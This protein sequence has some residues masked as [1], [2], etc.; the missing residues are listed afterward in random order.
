[1][2]GAIAGD[3]VGS[4]YEF[5][6]ITN[7]DF[8]PLFAEKCIYTDDTVLTVATADVI[9]DDDTTYSEQ[10]LDYAKAYPNRGYGGTFG[11]MIKLGKLIP[12]NSYG[13]GSAMRVS[14]VGWIHDTLEDT[15]AEAKKSA[16]CT[17]N[18]LEGVKG[19][20]A[21]AGVIFMARTGQ[22]KED[23]K[24]MVEWLGY[25]LS[26]KSYDFRQG[27]FDVT[28]QG[29]IPRCMAVI[30][31]T[32]DF[33]SAQRKTV[34]MGGDVD[35][36]CCIVGAIT[37]AMYG[38]PEGLTEAVYERLPNQMAEVVTA[39]TKKYIN[40]DFVEPENV[41]TMTATLEEQ[42]TSL[43]FGGDNEDSDT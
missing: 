31:E 17:H 10:Y 26:K 4:K 18:H 23:I 39:F 25:D 12:Y 19:A 7:E 9:L 30:L 38:L 43:V 1:M 41:G 21:V 40:K 33:E 5:H 2:I 24:S 27:K 37:E 13:N 15:L 42:L 14:P 36:N 6:N 32:D 34:A 20:Q 3:I 8:G 11:A 22:S 35:T 29:T 28:C 16:K